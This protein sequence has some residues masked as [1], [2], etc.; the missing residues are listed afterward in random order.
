V[1]GSAHESWLDDG[2]TAHAAVGTF[3]PNGFGLHEIAGNVVEW[4]R[5]RYCSYTVEPRAGD[6]LRNTPGIRDRV[7]RGGG[8]TTLATVARSAHRLFGSP[9]FRSTVL[10]LRPARILDE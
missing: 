7:Q 5:D 6:G 1:K 3:R 8:Y 10:G 4:C 9:D 2:Y